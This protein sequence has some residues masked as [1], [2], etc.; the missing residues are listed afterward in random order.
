ML[1]SNHYLPPRRLRFLALKGSVSLKPAMA[2]NT[3]TS[4]GIEIEDDLGRGVRGTWRLSVAPAVLLLVQILLYLW[5]AP[6]GFEF[7]DESFYLLNYLYWRDLTATVSF[8]GAYF[9]LPFRLVGQ[10]ITAIRVLTPIALIVASGFFGRELLRFSRRNEGGD[11]SPLLPFVLVVTAASFFYFGFFSSLRAPSYNLLALCAM[12]IAT[13]LLFRVANSGDSQS[14]FRGSAFC[15]GV[16]LGACTL[17]KAPTGALLLLFHAMFF[18]I[19]NPDWRLRRTIELCVLAAAGAALNVVLLEWADPGWLPALREGVAVT[20]ANGHGGLLDLARTA[21]QEAQALAPA[22]LELSLLATVIVILGRNIRVNRR[23]Q[24]SIAVVA[25]T[26]VCALELGQSQYRYMWLPTVVLS[27]VVIWSFEVRWLKPSQWGRVDIAAVALICLLFALPFA[28]S[29]G[30]NLHLSEHSQMAAVFGVSALVIRLDRLDARRVITKP[31]LAVSLMLLCLPTLTIQLQN[32]FDPNHAYRLRTALIDQSVAVGI[33]SA[34]ARV[35][36]DTTTRDV[37][38]AIE[39]AG[40]T[41]GFTPGQPI[42]DLTG[43]GPGVVYA[44]GGR[45]VGS[46]WLSGGYSGSEVA[47]ARLIAAIPQKQLEDAWLLT[48]RSNPRRIVGWQRLLDA[49]LGPGAHQLAATIRMQ[50][51]YQWHGVVPRTDVDLWRPRGVG[52]P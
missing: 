39:A 9:E 34:N 11:S 42:L 20:N 21:V 36:L 17:S 29:F 12:L 4:Q 15:Y 50:S 5:M 41:A 35:L 22:V 51:A 47:A 30:T 38:K 3:R 52:A 24:I 46:A 45:P 37:F 13:G 19:V 8:F 16:A 23:N 43:D 7:T 2:V 1:P 25:L 32:T 26:G 48:S 40:K 49:R 18:A 10:S 14:R 6:R 44:L 33:G 31:A 27:T 28:F